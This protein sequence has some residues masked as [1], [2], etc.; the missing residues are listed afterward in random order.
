M[1][2]HPLMACSHAANATHNASPEKPCKRTGLTVDHPSCVICMGIDPGA[3]TVSEKPSLEGRQAIC[4]YGR[5]KR[6]KHVPVRS[7]WDLA[8]FEYQGPGARKQSEFDDYYCGCF[9]WD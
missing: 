5:I 2:E 9:G 8:F 3:C 4:S 7:S 6:G 1:N